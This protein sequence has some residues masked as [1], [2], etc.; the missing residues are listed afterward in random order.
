MYFY[1]MKKIMLFSDVHG[2]LDALVAV[3]GDAF[4]GKS[5]IS[6]REL[7]RGL[8]QGISNKFEEVINLGDIV[9]YGRNPNE[10]I[11]LLSRISNLKSVSGNHDETVIRM[12]YG[13]NPEAAVREY[14]DYAR[15][16]IL[17]TYDNLS[18]GNLKW[19]VGNLTKKKKF[20]REFHDKDFL[21]C[22]S[23]PGKFFDKYVVI[24]KNGDKYKNN[25]RNPKFYDAWEALKEIKEP[26]LFVGHTHFVDRYKNGSGRT[27]W[28]IGSVGAPRGA[29]LHGAAVY[30]VYDRSL[31]SS[32][33]RK[34][35]L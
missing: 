21:A 3:L 12:H 25:G 9:G 31:N 24:Y 20:V 14:N 23:G 17:W 30:N 33:L 1:D 19:L 8:R 32:S 22:H 34:I 16:S 27:V 11:D 29:S 26:N 7:V 5:G 4:L 6:H 28:N 2:N 13:K 15:K 35:K 10:V 18:K